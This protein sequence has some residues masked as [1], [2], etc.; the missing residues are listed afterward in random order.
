MN[1][2]DVRKKVD[3][4]IVTIKPEE[5]EAVLKRFPPE[6]TVHG[7]SNRQYNITRVYLDSG[8][9]FLVAHVRC[10]KPGNAEG[11]AIVRDIYDELQPRVILL[12][13]IAGGSPHGDFTLGDVIVGTRVQDF[14]VSS[15]KPGGEIGNRVE[16]MALS[17][18]AAGIVANMPVHVLRMRPWNT[19]E[20]LG[21]SLPDTKRPASCVVDFGAT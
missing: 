8:E 14:S 13:G 17:K 10:T 5:M 20:A 11:Q 4:A 9:C 12:V 6:D 21:I 19:P 16:T 2:S 7:T 18:E 3:F 15:L 1:I